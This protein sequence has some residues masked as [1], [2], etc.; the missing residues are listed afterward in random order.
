MSNSNEADTK[1][2]EATDT[3][4]TFKAN[5]RTKKATVEAYAAVAT[6]KMDENI[7]VFGDQMID[8]G[9][10]NKPELA[11]LEGAVS[12][13]LIEWDTKRREQ[14]LEAARQLAKDYG[15]SLEDILT[16]GSK[17]N[18]PRKIKSSK[19]GEPR[20]RN[21]SNPDETWTG[22]GRRPKWVMEL[23]EAGK[24]MKDFEIAA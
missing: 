12:K 21:P 1:L 11:E 13:A 20:Y 4:P 22:H 3:T 8:L 2:S 23:Q 7:V 14:A 10:L 6:V 18:G 9:M 5:T 19:T 17:S 24:D 16:G 15:I